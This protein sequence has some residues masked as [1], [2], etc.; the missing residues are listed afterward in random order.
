M[1]RPL[2]YL[3][4]LL[5]LLSACGDKAK[6]TATATATTT[7]VAGP[8][9]SAKKP[10][11]PAK[12]HEKETPEACLAD[13]ATDPTDGKEFYCGTDHKTYKA[14]EWICDR[15]PTGVGVYPG[16]CNADG[17]PPAKH[18]PY[19]AD[20]KV[21]CDWFDNKG[22]WIA[23]EC[24]ESTE[25]KDPKTAF[26][27]KGAMPEGGASLEAA[28]SEPPDEVSHRARFGSIKNQ[29]S[30]PSCISFASTGALEG[31]VASATSSHIVLSEMHFLS[32]YHTT[33]YADAIATL[34]IGAALA[35]SA[36]SGGM[37]YSDAVA[38]A[39]IKGD[40]T[41]PADTVKELDEKIAFEVASVR[42]ITAEEGA[43]GVSARQL[44]VAIAD[45][46][47]LMV[48]FR[49]SD[50]WYT[51]NLLPGGII[52]DYDDGRNFGHAVLLV[53]YKT[54]EGK[55]YFEIRNS[56]G[57]TWADGGYG[58]ISFETAETN[59]QVAAAVSAQR[60]SD[61]PVEDCKSGEAAGFDG[62][63]RK[64]CPGGGLEENG[65]CPDD[66][67]CKDGKV[68]DGSNVCVRAC[69]TGQRDLDA[70]LSV[71]CKGEGCVWNIP[72]GTHGCKAA[73][74]EKCEHFCRAPDCEM[75]ES[76]NE[77]GVAVLGCGPAD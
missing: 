46:D 70:G 24:E 33:S 21:V 77:F 15:T 44:Q 74:G 49:M 61:I 26:H 52:A 58:Y 56:W 66:A 54:I 75:V 73:E 63:C 25:D 7:T 19:A 9:P 71:D 10:G 35:D 45:G 40:E 53:G 32:H 55:Q 42:E 48:G 36:K 72:G 38:G 18:P 60:R 23:V 62:K 43:N 22:Q 17:G 11:G 41:P 68:K 57:T 16:E 69:T 28:S 12:K 34:S 5:L 64:V 51:D 3:P 20:G 47:D 6:T 65:A 37:D 59:L 2:T 1:K 8:G 39:W 67:G 14:C 30:A 31:A 76:K 50:N 27:G 13:C 29:G 4:A